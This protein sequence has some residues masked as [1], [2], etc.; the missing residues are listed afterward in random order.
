MIVIKCGK[1]EWVGQFI[2]MPHV[3]IIAL[4]MVVLCLFQIPHFMEIMCNHYLNLSRLCME[5]L[6][7]TGAGMQMQKHIFLIRSLR[8]AKF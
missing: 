2:L 5:R 8:V 6:F 1:M 4:M 7:P 3:G